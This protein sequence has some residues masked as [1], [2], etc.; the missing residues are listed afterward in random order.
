MGFVSEWEYIE[1]VPLHLE[2][3]LATVLSHALQYIDTL[4]SATTT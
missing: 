4:N 1:R 2:M 3:T